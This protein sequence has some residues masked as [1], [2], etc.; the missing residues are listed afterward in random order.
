MPKPT[1]LEFPTEFPLKVMGRSDSEVRRAV[2]EI[3][4]KHV[5]PVDIEQ[6]RERKS[7]DGNFISL[8]IILQATSQAQ[9]DSIYRE[10][11]ACSSVLMSL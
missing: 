7:S 10:L 8:T 9:L 5:G 11:S 3:V 2:L 6:I 1:L 4:A